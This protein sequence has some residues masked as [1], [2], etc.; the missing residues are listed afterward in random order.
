VD[1]GIEFR[2]IRYLGIE[3]HVQSKVLEHTPAEENLA[4]FIWLPGLFPALPS[5]VDVSGCVSPAVQ[6]YTVPESYTVAHHFSQ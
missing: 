2:E 5:D 4:Q 6:V 1:N 3:M